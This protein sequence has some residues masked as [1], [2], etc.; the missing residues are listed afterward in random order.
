VALNGGSP[1][2]LF[3]GNAADTNWVYVAG[4]DNQSGT[5][6]NTMLD[7]QYGLAL[8]PS[9]IE[10]TSVGGVATITPTNL[11]T[12]FGKSVGGQNSGGT[13]ANT[14]TYVGSSTNFDP[15]LSKALHKARYGWYAIA[16]VGLFDADVALGI[17]GP[18]AL[19]GGVAVPLT[20]N[21]VPESA[22][23]II[24]GTYSF[25]GNEWIYESQSNL[26]SGGDT[27]YN[28]LIGSVNG[29][30]GSGIPGN[31]DGDHQISLTSM[32]ASKSN[33]GSDATHN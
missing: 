14:M 30:T 29:G 1:L 18:V 5:Y 26:S 17:Q 13:L 12:G 23:N 21:G 7:T 3:T 9:Q 27:V 4:R 19:P 8:S 16:Y 33:S 24:N 32:L 28:A 10:I 2:A 15:V 6:V 22:A 31:L 25:W 20:Y 11:I